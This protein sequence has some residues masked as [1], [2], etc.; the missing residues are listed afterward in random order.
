VPKRDLENLLEYKRGRKLGVRVKLRIRSNNKSII[1]AALVNSGYESDVPEIHV[2]LALAR[3]LGL[4]LEGVVSERYRVVGS[5]VSAYI[6]GTVKI[7]VITEDKESPEIEV[8]AVMVPGEYEVLLSDAT[9]EASEIEIIKP[10]TGQWRF[11]GEEKVRNSVQ[12]EY[13]VD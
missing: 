8:R 12:P 6:L 3:R 11:R 1:T 4:G 13:W 7:S 9:T 10:K 5:D 2:P